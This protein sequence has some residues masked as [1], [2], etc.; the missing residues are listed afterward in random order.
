[1]LGIFLIAELLKKDPRLWWF[2]MLPTDICA[3]AV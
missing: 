1:M 2:L 3:V